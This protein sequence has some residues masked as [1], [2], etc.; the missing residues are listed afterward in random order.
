MSF[1][2]D[3]SDRPHFQPPAKRTKGA[4]SIAWPDEMLAFGKTNS[5][6]TFKSAFGAYQKSF[7]VP[8]RK[9]RAR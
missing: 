6:R 3:P 7:I 9:N 4:A 8:K 5:G 1:L 2:I